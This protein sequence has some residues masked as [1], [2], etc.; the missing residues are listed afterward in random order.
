MKIDYEIEKKEKN[1]ID[2]SLT[3]P[4]D[5]F[6]KAYK[7]LLKKEAEKIDIKGFRKGKVPSEIIEPQ[8]KQALSLEALEQ[9]TPAYLTELI[10]QEKIELVAP[11]QYTQLPDLNK[12]QDLKL[13]IR[14]TIMPEFKLGD[15]KNIKVQ[16][17]SSEVK[18]EEIDNTI[19]EMFEKSMIEDKGKQPTDKWAEKTGKLYK[20][21][22]IKNLEDLKK[23]IEG[24]LK[25]EKD[26]IVTQN[27]HQE[28][29]T[30]A[31][32]LSKIEIPQEAIEFEAREREKSFLHELKNANMTLED[33][34]KNNN[35]DIKTLRELWEKDAKEALQ[36]DA[37]LKLYGKTNEITVSEKELEE[38]IENLKKS[39][40]E[41]IPE[42]VE[43][44][45]IWRNN[46]KNVIIKQ[47]AYKDLMEKVLK[48]KKEIKK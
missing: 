15:L 7:N 23:E 38:S 3:I 4:Y 12:E 22:N 20:L 31:V 11:P 21:E 2:A 9:I 36:A 35:T 25:K 10:K 26:R 16:K 6:D 27:A 33:F 1:H 17:E 32:E 39:R 44:D 47:K 43:K 5:V 18:T 41:E 37:L 24:L 19:K 13:N 34:C 48:E 14:F 45:E 29:M 28:V 40:Q 8:L 30:K 42:H 46:I